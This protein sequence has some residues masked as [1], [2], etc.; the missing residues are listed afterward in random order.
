MKKKV[1]DKIDEF[2]VDMTMQLQELKALF[3]IQGRFGLG[4]N[5]YL[6]NNENVREYRVV[7]ER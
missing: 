6:L 4:N 7:C 1:N 5:G 2:L 3:P